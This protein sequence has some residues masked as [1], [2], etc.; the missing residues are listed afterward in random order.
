[1][2]ATALWARSST[3]VRVPHSKSNKVLEKMLYCRSALRGLPTPTTTH[4]TTK[5]RTQHPRFL[6]RCI[7][8]RTKQGTTTTPC[9]FV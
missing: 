8:Y 6:L 1:M 5:L 4:T 7:G 2:I 3:T 9:A